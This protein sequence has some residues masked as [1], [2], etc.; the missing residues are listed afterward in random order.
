MRAAPS[1]NPAELMAQ[2]LWTLRE[3][4][5]RVLVVREALDSHEEQDRTIHMKEFMAIAG[6]YKCTEKEMVGLLYK[7]F[8]K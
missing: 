7:G 4:A 8:F 1:A 6:S 3:Y 2:H 5:R